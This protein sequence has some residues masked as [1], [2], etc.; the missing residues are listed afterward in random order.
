MGTKA[1]ANFT[2]NVGKYRGAA[3]HRY[4]VDIDLGPA[5]A[6]QLAMIRAVMGDKLEAELAIVKDKWV[7]GVGVNARSRLE[8]T[9]DLVLDGGPSMADSDAIKNV[10][11]TMPKDQSFVGILSIQQGFE[12]VKRLAPIPPN[13]A[14]TGTA[15]IGFTARM[16]GRQVNE[17]LIVPTSEI[18]AVYQMIVSARMGAG[19]QVQPL[20]QPQQ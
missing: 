5:Q 1:L 9:V 18:V 10:F 13:M 20:P 8:Q 12:W 19:A 7:M 14:Y 4:A 16:A 2:P 17:R 6:P 11:G 3:I 15:G